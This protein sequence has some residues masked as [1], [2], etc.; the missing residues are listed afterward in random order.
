MH[1]KFVR[2]TATSYKLNWSLN[3]KF[4]YNLAL[5]NKIAAFGFCLVKSPHDSALVAQFMVYPLC[6]NLWTLLTSDAHF[7]VTPCATKMVRMNIYT[8][9]RLCVRIDTTHVCDM[10]GELLILNHCLSTQCDRSSPVDWSQIQVSVIPDRIEVPLVDIQKGLFVPIPP[11]VIQ[12]ARCNRC[13][14][15]ERM[16]RLCKRHKVCPHRV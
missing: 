9:K 16:K 5:K 6:N 3:E 4:L 7:T 12:C 10:C 13:K 8:P 15:C 2:Y 14:L 1:S 11:K